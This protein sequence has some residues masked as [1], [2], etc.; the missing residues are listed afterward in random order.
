MKRIL[1]F[2]VAICPFFVNAQL[3]GRY[4]D[5]LPI[6]YSL[7][8]SNNEEGKK[9]EKD[10]DGDSE[11]DLI[12]QLFN[13]D[14][15]AIIVIY[16]SSTFYKDKTY[17]WFDWIFS[18]NDLNVSCDE[19]IEISSG[20]ESMGIFQGLTLVYSNTQKKMIVESYEDSSGE[21]SFTL[22]SDTIK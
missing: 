4:A 16:L 11:E 18:G 5:N 1:L 15:E 8:D 22:N 20:I 6:G 14:N 3:K 10:I 2:F 19:Q 9:C 13:A 7:I 12:T 21:D 17:Q